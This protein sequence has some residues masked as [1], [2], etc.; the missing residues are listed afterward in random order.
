MLWCACI[1][2]IQKGVHKTKDGIIEIAKL[3][4]CMNNTKQATKRSPE[5]LGEL[6]DLKL[7]ERRQKFEEHIHNNFDKIDPKTK[8]VWKQML[9]GGGLDKYSVEILKNA[10]S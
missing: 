8:R 2:M 6:F 5:E 9:E 3:R 7:K 1:E 4:D 10:L